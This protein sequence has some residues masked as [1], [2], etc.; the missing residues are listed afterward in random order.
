MQK[1]IAFRVEQL[2]DRVVSAQCSNG[3]NLV[4]GDYR[5]LLSFMVNEPESY[6]KSTPRV[7]WN[8]SYFYSCVRSLLPDFAVKMLDDKQRR[9]E[10]ND[11]GMRYRLFYQTGKFFGIH[12][13]GWGQ[14]IT[15]YELDQFFEEHP[16]VSTIEAVQE[17]ADALVAAFAELGVVNI[18][19]LNSPVS[20]LENAGVVADAYKA[21]PDPGEI[22][23]E[24]SE[25]A[26]LSNVYGAWHSAY[27]VGYWPK[28][29]SYSA[30]ISSCY[31]SIA[32]GLVSLE[33]AEYKHSK[34]PIEGALYGFLKGTMFVD[35]ASPFAF[36]S[37]I[38]AG[39]GDTATNY[40]GKLR[41]V[42]TLGQVSFIERHRMGTF[43]LKDGYYIT[44]RP[45]LPRPLAA[46]M[47][48]LYAMRS[49]GGLVS[50]LAKRA[51]NGILG[52]LDEYRENNTVPTENTNAVYHSII[53]NY[54]GCKVA[55][56]LIQNEFTQ[57][58]LIHVATDG[59]HSTRM[60]P[61]PPRS[62]MGQWRT[63]GSDDLIVLSPNTILRGEQCRELVKTIR[64]NK[65]TTR[66]VIGDTVYDLTSLAADQDR[67]FDKYPATGG[68]LL[69]RSYSSQPLQI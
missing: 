38:L 52:R 2:S 4:T 33:G 16:D 56:Y 35:P 24:V 49:R 23:G 69:R 12:A 40:V 61:L 47:Q 13:G 32:A 50:F 64:S 63:E 21:L 68:D 48:K 59:F 6:P 65:K 1:I 18:E 9:A 42:F 29:A 15:V 25:Y 53:V 54:A 27:Q 30:D 46:P 36:C 5:K 60:L 3:K 28:G 57:D 14:E 41:G 51:M 55:D 10:W 26:V 34:K 62:A 58:E 8:L 45:G 37:P 43:T 7:V 17:A 11:Q 31:P 19:N 66:Y 20:V 44:P 22:P 67:Y 39:D